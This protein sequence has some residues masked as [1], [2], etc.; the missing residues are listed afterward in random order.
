MPQGAWRNHPHFLFEERGTWWRN[1]D[2]TGK[3]NGHLVAQ[4]CRKDADNLLFRDSF[5]SALLHSYH[6]ST[7]ML[8]ASKTMGWKGRKLKG[9]EWT[10]AICRSERSE[11]AKG[12]KE[13]LWGKPGW[14]MTTDYGWGQEMEDQRIVIGVGY[15]QGAI[16]WLTK[17]DETQ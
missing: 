17:K 3:L 13:G 7:R 14:N 9:A 12:W 1:V 16:R 15:L 10:V 2:D 8:C 6:N 11:N 5:S 4:R